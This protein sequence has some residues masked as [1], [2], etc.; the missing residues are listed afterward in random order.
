METIPLNVVVYDKGEFMR[1]FICF[2]MSLLMG[3]SM[4][5][6]GISSGASNNDNEDSTPTK[7]LQG[8]QIIFLGSSLTL[9]DNGYSMCEYLF[10]THGCEVTKW[11]INS[12]WLI[13]RNDGTSYVERLAKNAEF[14]EECDFFICQLSTN[15]SGIPIGEVSGSYLSEDFDTTTIIGAI[16]FVIAKAKETWGCPV[17]FYTTAYFK[18][19]TY[20]SWV[21]ALYKVQEKW[22]KGKTYFGIIDLYGDKDF[23]DITDEQREVYF[24]ADGVHVTQ[25]AYAEWWGPQFANFLLDYYDKKS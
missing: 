15:G 19:S 11:A 1:K 6:C 10:E 23:N 18:S 3:F 14:V 25:K 16:E 8:K 2:L 22:N 9:G 17:A 5:S 24:K 4:A 12:T 21:N 7:P 20:P 13:H